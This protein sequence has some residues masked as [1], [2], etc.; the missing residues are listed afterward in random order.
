MTMKNF[1]LRG[2]SRLPG[3][4]DYAIRE[5]QEAERAHLARELHDDLG[6]YL[7]AMQAQAYLT[8]RSV[9]GSWKGS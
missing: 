3:L 1:L 7:T 8:C 2:K 9:R 4:G 5:V 6:R